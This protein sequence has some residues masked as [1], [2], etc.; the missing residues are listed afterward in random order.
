MKDFEH[1]ANYRKSLTE[2]YDLSTNVLD[3]LYNIIKQREDGN[4]NNEKLP[5][6]LKNKL[7]DLQ[8]K[9]TF[10][11]VQLIQNKNLFKNDYYKINEELTKK[12]KINDSS[13]N[14]SFLLK[15]DIQNFKN[16][17]QWSL[18]NES[19]LKLPE[20]QITNLIDFNNDDNETDNNNNNNENKEFIKSLD[21]SLNDIKS[22]LLDN[23]QINESDKDKFIIPEESNL[24][25][26]KILE[27]SDIK[28]FRLV[29]LHD[30]YYERKINMLKEM[31]RKW[32]FEINKIKNFVSLDV[33]KMKNE[34]N[35]K[36]EES[37]KESEL[38]NESENLE[39]NQVNNEIIDYEDNDENKEINEDIEVE[40]D[41][42]EDLENHSEIDESN[43]PD[44]TDE[45]DEPTNEMDVDV[46]IDN[47]QTQQCHEDDNET[48]EIEE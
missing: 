20:L 46:D 23:N 18:L 45:I 32:K 21:F 1:S 41:D 4:N 26:R 2:S 44:E 42:Q 10:D 16:N 22:L 27:D 28:K 38:E 37:N 47:E 29:Q 40:S 34:L 12:I 31:N 7:N 48:A 43:E 14:N 36:L 39:L 19:I 15:L 30:K 3:E 25:L 5:I 24:K 13:A 33:N 8:Y 6:E 11:T 17:K 35:N 9:M